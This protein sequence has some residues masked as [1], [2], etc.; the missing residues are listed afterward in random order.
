MRYAIRWFK[1]KL[2]PPKKKGS[3]YSFHHFPHQ[4]PNLLKKWVL[5]IRRKQWKPTKHSFICS[6]HFHE[7]CFVIRPGAEG[8]RLKDDAVPSIFQTFPSYYQKDIKLRRSP[9]K[10]QYV[11]HEVVAPSEVEPSTSGPSPSELQVE[12]SYFAVPESPTKKVKKLESTVEKYG[13]KLHVL[14]QTVRRQKKK[15]HNL[16]DLVNSLK[17][18]KLVSDAQQHLL[19]QNFD[20]VGKYL[21]ENQIANAKQASKQ[22]ICHGC[23]LWA[24]NT[25]TYFCANW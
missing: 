1:C 4:N 2:K 9:R 10:R 5:A 25:H 12:H 11:A 18:Q 8:R 14:Q 19:E 16:K 15:I 13:K 6:D 17:Q 23:G 24:S 20:G 21:F 7:S 3:E 22:A